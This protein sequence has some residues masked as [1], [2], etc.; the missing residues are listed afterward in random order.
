MHV[1]FA[2]KK[3]RMRLIT[4]LF[5][6]FIMSTNISAQDI[7]WYSWEEAVELSKKSPKKVFIDLY[8]DW[9]GWCKRMDATTFKDANIIKYINDNFYA[10]KFNAEQQGE[11]EFN[12]TSFKFIAQGRRGVHQLAYALLD[13]RLGYPAFVMLDETYARIMVSPGYKQPEQ[14]IKEL[15]FAKEEKYKEMTWESYSSSE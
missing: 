11:I 4:V 1:I 14:L 15:Q 8:T 7:K 12:G 13:G 2:Y 9:C 3:K 6:M 10:V 5:L